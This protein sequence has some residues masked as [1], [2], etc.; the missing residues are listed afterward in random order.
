MDADGDEVFCEIQEWE[1][2]RSP[3]MDTQLYHVRRFWNIK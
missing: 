1:A 2:W 3:E